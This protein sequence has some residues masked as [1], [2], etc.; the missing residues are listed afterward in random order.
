VLAMRAVWVHSM[1]DAVELIWLPRPGRLPAPKHAGDADVL[2]EFG[3]MNAKRRQFDEAAGAR[4]GF[5]EP[6]IPPQRSTQHAAVGERDVEER[7]VAMRFDGTSTSICKVVTP[8]P[9]NASFFA[10]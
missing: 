2:V 5:Q 1:T 10:V 6:G 8:S 7:L 9:R 3:P 4:L